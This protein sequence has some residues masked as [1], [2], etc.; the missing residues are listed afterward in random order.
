[1]N[2]L[3]VDDEE[4]VAQTLGRLLQ[5]LGHCSQTASSG[6]AALRCLEAQT[7]DLVLTD[8]QMPGAR[9]KDSS[10]TRLIARCPNGG[11]L[12]LCNRPTTLGHRH[13]KSV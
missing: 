7:P 10:D 2:I 4:M 3:L 5:R 6:M 9:A 13:L 11:R 1:M 12:L 8:V